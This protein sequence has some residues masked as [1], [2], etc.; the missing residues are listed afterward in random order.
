MD[1]APF[2]MVTEVQD[3][4]MVDRLSDAAATTDEQDARGFCDRML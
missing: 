1:F 2:G 4:K 3:V